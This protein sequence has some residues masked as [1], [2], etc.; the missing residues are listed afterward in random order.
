MI[1]ACFE[2]DKP[3]RL[4]DLILQLQQASHSVQC[5]LLS[6]L[7]QGYII[8]FE[9]GQ[10]LSG[11]RKFHAQWERFWIVFDLMSTTEGSTHIEA[12]SNELRLYIL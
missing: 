9:D 1:D 7:F 2:E 10:Y 12:C 8:G 3:I 6:E 5:D 4:Q 11:L